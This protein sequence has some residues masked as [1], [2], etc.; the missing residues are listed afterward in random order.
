MESKIKYMPTFRSRQQEIIVLKSFDFGNQMFPLLEIV[1]EHD[2][3]RKDQK[4]FSEI[5]IE[6]IESIKA[7]RVFVDLPLY[8]KETGAMQ[9]EVFIFSRGIIA[10]P[11]RRTQHLLML[12]DLNSKIIP[13]VSSYIIKTGEQGTLGRQ[14]MELR[15]NFKV[16]CFRTYITT[17]ENEIDEIEKSISGEDFLILDL[18]SLPPYHTSP[19]LRKIV[20]RFKNITN[21]NKIVLRSAI[22]TDIQ[23]VTLEHGGIIYEADNSLL[24]NFKDFGAIAFGD[25]VGVK[26]DDLSAG[27]TISPGFI[28]YD[29]EENQYYG[30][31]GDIKSLSEFERTIVP[32]VIASEATYRMQ[33]N[34]LDYL[35][36]ENNG[37]ETLNQISQ[38]IESGKS[39][40]KF[41]K[42]AMEHYLHCMKMKINAGKL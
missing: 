42:I 18:D 12:K 4:S 13:V 10:D 28:Y 29:A 36:I 33:I 41:K 9:K 39:Q 20:Q 8:L 24:D 16:I 14:V 37:W 25:Y 5:Y 3:E 23:N 21:Q 19:V 11:E 38:G 2:R 34:P 1:K 6:L 22:N 35:S 17:F 30:F 26:K 7:Q 40:A 31:K 32:D 15:S 27:G